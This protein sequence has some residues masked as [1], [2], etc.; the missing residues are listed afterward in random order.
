MEA[1]G[2]GL[3]LKGARDEFGIFWD[4]GAGDNDWNSALNWT[5]NSV[6]TSGQN[7]FLEHTNGGISAAYR[8]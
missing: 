7:I 4:N 3:W 8:F 2:Q 1:G 6:P 5:S